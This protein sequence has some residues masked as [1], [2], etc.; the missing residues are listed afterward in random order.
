ML[1]KNERVLKRKDSLFEESGES[2]QYYD[3]IFSSKKKYIKKGF[4]HVKLSILIKKIHSC[5]FP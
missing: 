4:S 5:F 3:R 1:M 2:F